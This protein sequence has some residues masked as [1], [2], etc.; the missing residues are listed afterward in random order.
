MKLNI[1]IFWHWTFGINFT[2]QGLKVCL[3]VWWCLSPLSTIFQLFCGGQ[4]Y[5]WRKP[6][7]PRKPKLQQ[8]VASH[9]QT[10]RPWVVKLMPNVQCQNIQIFNFILGRVTWQC[11]AIKSTNWTLSVFCFTESVVGTYHQLWCDM[12]LDHLKI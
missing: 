9:R 1:W 11:C 6:E 5:W 12:F 7:D 10:F 2:T 3:F 4:F 8:L